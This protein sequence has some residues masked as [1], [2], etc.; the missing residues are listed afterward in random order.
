MNKCLITRL[1][2]SV[3]NEDLKELGVIK[4]VVN[5]DSFTLSGDKKDTKITWNGVEV[6]T[7]NFSFK[8]VGVFRVMNK[9]TMT[10]FRINKVNVEDLRYCSSLKDLYI[11]RDGYGNLD[12]TGIYPHLTDFNINVATTDTGVLFGSID[13]LSQFKSLQY[14]TING[15]GESYITGD[16][17]C[18][19]NIKS[20]KTIKIFGGDINNK[21]IKGDIKDLGNLTNLTSMNFSG[22]K[23]VGGK[24]EQFVKAQIAAG[25]TTNSDGIA[26]P[27]ISTSSITYFGTQTSV[28]TKVTWDATTITFNGVTHSLSE[29]E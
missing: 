23:G 10:K 6:D 18:L 1:M 19:S 13:G 2:S 27:H 11:E 25:R 29:I 9:Y 22:C 16:I 21:T 26:I 4:V 14:L 8:G 7:T 28:N 5:D 17:Y 15:G 3:S 20:L 24:I 12:F